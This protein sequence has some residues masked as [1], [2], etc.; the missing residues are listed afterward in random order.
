MLPHGAAAVSCLEDSTGLVVVAGHPWVPWNPATGISAALRMGSVPY[1]WLFAGGMGPG[2]AFQDAGSSVLV[3]F[4][5]LRLLL[6]I[7]NISEF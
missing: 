3:N 5:L 4:T 7:D 1:G 2:V 6:I